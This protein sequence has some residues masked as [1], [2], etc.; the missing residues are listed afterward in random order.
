MALPEN[1]IGAYD[2]DALNGR[3]QPK[4]EQL[5]VI[6]RP[7]HD[8]ETTR[9]TGVRGLPSQIQTLHYVADRT[10]AQTAIVAYTALIGAAPQEITQRDVSFGYFKIINV[11]EVLVADCM[12]VVNPL[13]ADPTAVQIVQW[14][15][16]ST[17][18]P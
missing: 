13:I 14:T 1:S 11:V 4:A 10:A 17:E 5:E 16:V 6:V 8:G 7:G 18:A 12:K 2:F 9:K 3:L 15:V